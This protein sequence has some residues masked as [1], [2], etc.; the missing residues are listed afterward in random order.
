[1]SSLKKLWSVL[2]IAALALAVAACSDNG[3]KNDAGAK[4]KG[5][6][7]DSVPAPSKLTCS[8]DCKDFVMS[9]LIFPD[10]QTASQIGVDYNDDDTVDN[11]LGSILGAL[12]GVT[13]S[14]DLQ[15]SVDEAMNEGSTIMLLRVQAK[16]FTNATTAAS[17]AWVGLD[18]KCCTS[19][20][21]AKK[22]ATEAK[23]TCFSGSHT[24][25]PDKQASDA[26]AIFGGYING[27]QFE[28]GSMGSTMSLS[29][30]ITGQALNLNL[31]GV[32]IKG[33]VNSAGTSIS[34]GILAGVVT[35]SDL[36]TELL[37]NIVKMLNETLEDPKTEESTKKTILSMFDD[38]NDK[39]ISNSE[40]TENALIKTFLS[41]DVDID[42][43]KKMELSLGVEFEAVSATIDDTGTKPDAGTT[44]DSSTTVDAAA[45]DAGSGG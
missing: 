1:M 6:R 36:D 14:L 38:N 31:K 41:G 17:Q 44:P 21:D 13:S 40:V 34:K 32:F 12:S 42:G 16:D 35:K 11:A 8:G 20:S 23:A 15:K 33:T 3:E 29:L 39:K 22:C 28:F 10:A 27:G 26:K 30:P 37:P 43:D 18:D 5:V 45:S 24:F 4:D 7:P 2:M 25:Y 19:T 9:R